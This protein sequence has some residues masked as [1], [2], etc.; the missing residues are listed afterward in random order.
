LFAGLPDD[1]GLL[2]QLTS[3]NLRSNI[4]EGS[5]PSFFFENLT[6]LGV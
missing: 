4:L 2:T 3:I 6:K 5:I 1:V